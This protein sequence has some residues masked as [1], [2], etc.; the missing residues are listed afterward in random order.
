LRIFWGKGLI[1]VALHHLGFKPKAHSVSPLKR[2]EE[3]FRISST[4]F[5]GFLL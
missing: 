1:V 4:R 2:T 3:I 5:N